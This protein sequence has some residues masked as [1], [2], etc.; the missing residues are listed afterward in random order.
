MLTDVNIQQFLEECG[1]LKL[2]PNANDEKPD[3]V[4]QHTAF[5][6]AQLFARPPTLQDAIFSFWS[7]CWPGWPQVGRYTEFMAKVHEH[8][9]RNQSDEAIQNNAQNF[10]SDAYLRLELNQCVLI[11]NTP[12]IFVSPSDATEIQMFDPQM[13]P[14]NLVSAR[15]GRIN[16]PSF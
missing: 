8:L 16:V 2:D 11:V 10:F 1:T 12:D 6:R 15:R 9:F 7:W 5:K 13:L 4:V 3:L 14:S